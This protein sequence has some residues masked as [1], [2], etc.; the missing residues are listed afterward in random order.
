MNEVIKAFCGL[1][2]TGEGAVLSTIISHSGSTPRRSGTK[3]ISRR[4]GS[5]IGT[6]GGGIVEADVMAA[7]SDIF[8]AKGSLVRDLD[9]QV[10][11][12]KESL[13]SLCGGRMTILM[14][15]V[16][17][18]RKNLDLYRRISEL[19]R[20]GRKAALV[21]I[22]PEGSGIAAPVR[23]FL[24]TKDEVFPDTIPMDAGDV[25]SLRSTFYGHRT[26]GLKEIAGKSWL[27]EPLFNSG[28]VFIFGAGHVSL[29]LAGLSHMVDFNTVVLDD[30]AEFA[31][32]DRFE[33]V[34]D[35]IV[36]D[37]FESAFDAIDVNPDSYIVIVTRGHSHD[38]IVLEQALKSDAGYIGMI[39]S[40]MKRDAIYS[41]LLKEG[42]TR[43]DLKRV[44]SPIGLKI[45]AETP[46]EIAVSIIGE[47]IASRAG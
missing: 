21:G 33:T 14:E 45:E 23:R 35:I 6:I 31:N 27:V 28:T 16:E 12:R 37:R 5:I 47:L 19:L 24:I 1:L 11:R 39:G 3:M 30:R 2:E 42:F 36:L 34:D 13:D 46:E 25:H 26:P 15:W 32:R 38:K 20:K 43:R 10:G 4:D 22:L 29:Q 44:H 41:A 7:A 18:N 8:S 40:R 9:L 17:A